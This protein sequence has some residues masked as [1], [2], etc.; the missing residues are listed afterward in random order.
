MNSHLLTAY[1]SISFFIALFVCVGITIAQPVINGFTPATASAGATVTISGNNFNTTP[2]NNT[3]LFGAAKAIVLSASTNMLA[4]KVP[5]GA[6]F[7]RITVTSNGSRLFPTVSRY[8]L[9]AV[10]LGR[11]H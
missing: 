8:S 6:T 11:L 5:V 2:N 4:V 7:G 3:V 10:R 1:K 9:T